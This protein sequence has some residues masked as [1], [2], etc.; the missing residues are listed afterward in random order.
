MV[1]CILY[2]GKGIGCGVAR[3]LCRDFG[4]GED[5]GVIKCVWMFC[6]IAIVVVDY[7]DG[8]ESVFIEEAA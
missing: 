7:S 2:D 1:F 4:C 6:F 8:K 3:I 5:S